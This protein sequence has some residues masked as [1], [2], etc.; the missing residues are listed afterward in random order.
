M[1]PLL[2]FRFRPR[3]PQQVYDIILGHLGSD[4]RNMAVDVATG[5][6]QAAV[7]LAE[8]FKQVCWHGVDWSSGPVSHITSEQGVMPC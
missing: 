8:Y 5:S 3:Y 1:Q 7:Q 4:Q 6:G 2:P